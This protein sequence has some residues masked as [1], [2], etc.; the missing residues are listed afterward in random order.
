MKKSILKKNFF[1][2]AGN[3]STMVSEIYWPNTRKVE[4][5]VS[6]WKMVKVTLMTLNDIE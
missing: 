2:F 4:P 3:I 5:S 6:L 1:R